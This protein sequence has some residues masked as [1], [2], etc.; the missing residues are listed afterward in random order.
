MKILMNTISNTEVAAIR[1]QQI[2]DGVKPDQ[3]FTGT[4]TIN[5]QLFIQ[6]EWTHVPDTLNTSAYPF[7]KEVSV[8]LEEETKRVLT[9]N[10]L[11]NFAQ[12]V[13][14]SYTMYSK[15]IPPI[16]VDVKKYA[17][18]KISADVINEELMK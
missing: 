2:K 16:A 10:G 17:P 8:H 4:Y 11:N 15:E 7:I 13:A 12:G 6:G 3:L 5:G 9:E 14:D 1:E 18:V